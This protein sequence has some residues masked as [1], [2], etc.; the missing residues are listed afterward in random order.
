MENLVEMDRENFY[1]KELLL[2]ANFV[3]KKSLSQ[4]TEFCSEME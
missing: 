3:Q 4:A 1:A 2:E